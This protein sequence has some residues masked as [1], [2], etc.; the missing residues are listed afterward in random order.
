MRAVVFILEE[1]VS[2][3]VAWTSI[4]MWSA[5]GTKLATCPVWSAT[6]WTQTSGAMCRLCLSRW[7]P[8]QEQ[9][10][11]GKYTFQASHSSISLCKVPRPRHLLDPDVSV[12]HR[13]SAQRRVCP[14]VVL[15]WPGHGCLGPQTRHEHEAC[16]P[17]S[18][19]DERS[20]VCNWRESFER[21]FLVCLFSCLFV[22]VIL[23]CV[24]MSK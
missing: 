11:M 21:C 10:T 12:L 15:L 9:C 3:H 5:G 8:T 18:G 22:F 14:V 17:H 13:G 19:C 1:P 4:Y 16:H 23:F 20:L 24:S 2:T 7:Q 6:T